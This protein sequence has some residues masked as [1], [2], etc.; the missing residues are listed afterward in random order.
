MTFTDS[1]ISDLLPVIYD[2]EKPTGLGTSNPSN[3]ELTARGKD[4]WLT[5]LRGAGEP[6]RQ[7]W[8]RLPGFHW[9][10]IV[11]KSRPG[12]EVL[13]VHSNFRNDWGRMPTLAIRYA[14]AGKTLFLGS[15]G[16]WRWRRGVEDKYHYR[17]WSQVVRWM[18]HG[19]Y[20]AE[21]EG[22]RLIPDPERPKSGENVFVRCIVLDKAGFPMEDGEVDGLIIHPNGQRE[23]LRF[24]AEEEGPGVYLGS[25]KA[26]EPGDLRMKVKTLPAER[27][28]D[29]TLKVERQTKEKLGQ[30][31][32]SR[33]LLQLARLTGR[34]IS[35]LSRV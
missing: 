30:P 33:D 15:D 4:H 8:D 20:L 24:A 28:L 18:A 16:A 14:G 22:I 3:L 7:F 25:F 35:K 11:S 12:S 2:P 23:S 32:V 29:M 26:R 27:E 6:D 10:A 17:F 9:S 5:N 1:P 31:V 19:R 34:E 21:K 13:A